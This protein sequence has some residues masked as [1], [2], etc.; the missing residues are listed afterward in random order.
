[1]YQTIKNYT[2]NYD[3]T[4]I[5]DKIHHEI[6]QFCSAHT[7]HEVYISL[8]DTLDEHLATRL[9]RDCD[10]WAPGIEIISVRVTK[11]KIPDTIRYNFELMEA[12]KTK[13]LI[14]TETQKVIEKEAETAKKKATIEAQMQADV[15][16]IR[17][18]VELLRK[19]TEKNISA[20]EDQIHMNKKIAESDS[21]FYK[22]IKEAEANEKL[23]TDP[24]IEYM[25]ILSLANNTKVYFGDKLPS[26]YVDKTTSSSSGGRGGGLPSGLL[27]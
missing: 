12:E 21:N 6:N 24:Y 13:L 27:P 11:P 26:I 14:A 16:K 22:S 25:R 18:D 19:E 17:M 4:W 23:L 7:L 1:M 15:S 2:I 3:K 8:F 20:L 10:N 5:F 9:Q